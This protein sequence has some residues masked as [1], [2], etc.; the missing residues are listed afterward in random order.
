MAD[1]KEILEKFEILSF[2]WMSRREDPKNPSTL[3]FSHFLTHRPCY[4]WRISADH[5]SSLHNPVREQ[6]PAP[7]THCWCHQSWDSSQGYLHHSCTRQRRLQQTCPGHCLLSHSC[8]FATRFPAETRQL[9]GGASCTWTWRGPCGWTGSCHCG[10]SRPLGRGHPQPEVEDMPGPASRSWGWVGL[11][12]WVWSFRS[13]PL[14]LCCRMLS[15]GCCQTKWKSNWTLVHWEPF[16]K[17]AWR[18]EE[19]LELESFV[20]RLWFSGKPNYTFIMRF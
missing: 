1:N 9:G 12:S 18:Q 4:N 8:R 17:N 3:D 6:G 13:L 5:F 11:S 16:M 7:L 20:R 15:P 14:S 2:S 19:R 10:G